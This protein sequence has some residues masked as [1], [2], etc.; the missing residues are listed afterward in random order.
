MNIIRVEPPNWW[1]GMKAKTV[2][3]LIYGEG[4]AECRPS[5]D[6][7]NARIV[8][9]HVSD[10]PDH[11]FVELRVNDDAQPCEVPLLFSLAGQVVAKVSYQLLARKRGSAERQGVSSADAVYLLMPDRF[12]SSDADVGQLPCMREKI[13]RRA[14]YGRHGG[15]INGIRRHLDY[16]Y[17]LG[18]TALWTTPVLTNDMPHS[19][20]HGYAITNF[21]EVDPRLG[22]LSDYRALSAA[23]HQR[24][25]KLIMDI[26]VNHCGTCHPW[27]ASPPT[28]DWL[29]TWGGH[30][31]RTNYR[32]SVVSDVHA[33][34]YDRKR[35]VEGW[36]DASM[37]DV[38]MGNPLVVQYFA[39]C[40][41]WWIETAD[42]DAIRMDT[43]PYSEPSGMAAWCKTIMDEYPNFNII[44]ETWLSEA[45]KLSVWQRGSVSARW[46][47]T[48]LKSVMDFPVQE[49]V[50][51]AFAEDFFWG[52]GA[53]RLYDAVAN[54]HLYSDS[55]SLLV[56][57]DNHDTGRLLHRLLDDEEA[58]RLA[59]VF[60]ATTRGI[61][62]LYYGTEVLLSGDADKGHSHIRQDFPGGWETD[63]HDYFDARPKRQE[64]MYD[65]VSNLF[66]FRKGCKALQIGKLTHFVPTENVYVYFRHTDDEVVMV[67][68]NISRKRVALHM[69]IYAE[70]VGDD[71]LTGRDALSGRKY[72][73][74]QRLS[75]PARRA[76]I[77]VLE[78]R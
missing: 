22:S 67:A 45:S 1:V 56:F 13:N 24:G 60:I 16:I 19:S 32:P 58:L 6:S 63:Q 54:D 43:V 28:S 4:V 46:T 11:L 77:V 8:A 74:V 29:N 7:S 65:F 18:M 21:Y 49:A 12:A 57:G 71:G 33:S 73:H 30:E 76:L 3:L 40:A 59:L 31:Q 72:N 70:L 69:G 44:G 78:R 2:T 25:M 26:V 42:L 37:A 61:P 10:S 55:L 48:H 20:Y 34:N 36:F 9:T 38:N 62:Q 15:N 51:R 68:L 39:Q 64:E 53:N 66:S 47:D 5:A 75:V 27:L 23:L 17:G 41:Q 50:S 52:M 14:P 35:T